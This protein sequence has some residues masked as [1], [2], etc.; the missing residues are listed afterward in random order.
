MATARNYYAVLNVS[1]T[2]TQDEIK[3][4]YRRL[5]MQHHPDKGGDAEEFKKINEA[6]ETLGRPDVKRQYDQ[7]LRSDRT[8]NHP[9]SAAN[10]A[11]PSFNVASFFDFT[12]HKSVEKIIFTSGLPADLADELKSLHLLSLAFKNKYPT[13]DP[14]EII[15]S[16]I[17]NKTEHYIKT[18]IHAYKQN[19]D[20]KT[21]LMEGVALTKNALTNPTE[22]NIKLCNK[23]ARKLPSCA[24][25]TLKLVAAAT[26]AFTSILVAAVGFGSLLLGIGGLA[27]GILPLGLI[28][29]GIGITALAGGAGGIY[30]GMKLFGDIQDSPDLSMSR[31]Y[32]SITKDIE[33]R[34]PKPR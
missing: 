26:L 29:T 25:K 7:D 18:V 27:T 9:A 28:L 17:P 21:I 16:S 8:F 6:Y 12:N 33:R 22:D 23:H 1:R 5:A 11:S 10:T 31:A 4:A 3:K 14:F 32:S 2:A 15:S 24:P 34:A 20:Q 30:G 19:P 13:N